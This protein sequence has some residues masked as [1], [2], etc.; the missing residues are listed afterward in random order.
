MRI[1]IKQTWGL[2]FLVIVTLIYLSISMIESNPPSEEPVEIY[3]ADRIT[4]AHK[5]LI[6]KY[7]EMH[8]GKV[9]VVTIDFP[10]FNF[11]TNERKELLARSLRGRGDGIDILAVDVI[12]VQRF[13]K[14]CEPLDKYFTAE[15]KSKIINQALKSCYY[16]GE[17]VAFPLDLV[18]GIMYYREDLLKKF[19][20][21][22]KIIAKI[23]N[24]ITWEDFIKLGKKL[25][26]STPF[27]IFPAA[28]YEGLVC[29]FVELIMSIDQF[30]FEKN[31]FDL[32]TAEAAKALQ[33]LVDLVNKHR[34]TPSDVTG[35]TEVPSYEYFI[36]NDALF[37]RG[38]PSYDK[39]FKETPFDTSKEKNLKKVAVPYF[40]DGRPASVFGGWNLMVSKFSDKKKE[41]V[42]FIKYLVSDESQ[43]IFYRSAGYYPVVKNFYEDEKFLV[44]YPEIKDYKKLIS[45]GVHRPAHVEYTRY[46]EIMSYYF[47]LAI[48]NEMPVKEALYRATNSIH[49]ERIMLKD[50]NNN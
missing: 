45:A 16:E 49:S 40:E 7:N 3:F 22:E 21:S 39:D 34:L 6:D 38:W 11:S 29:S 47:E 35:F 43:E 18:Q 23:E 5:I 12:W 28:D 44:K 8:K 33:L 2:L 4:A 13:A 46:S 42:D 50:F 27:Y 41:V 9:K 24:D 1:R 25:Q 32:N 36:E 10:N 30:Y 19:P 20:E 37:I 17:L 14:W 15:D 26:P 48:K 31:G